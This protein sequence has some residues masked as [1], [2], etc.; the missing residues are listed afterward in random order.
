MLFLASCGTTKIANS[1]PIFT[2]INLYQNV[3][4][5]LGDDIN[6]FNNLVETKDNRT[7]LKESVFGGSNSIELI[8][9]ADNKISEFIFDY[10]TN[11]SLESKIKEYIYLGEPKRKNNKAI[12]N[13][14]KTEFSI[15]KS[16][17]HV[18]SKMKKID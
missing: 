16:N 6:K 8:T 2:H 11:I 17:G 5:G 18:F 15:Y 10:G 9:N 13:D 7:Y 12:W 1:R 14:T 4:I 3:K